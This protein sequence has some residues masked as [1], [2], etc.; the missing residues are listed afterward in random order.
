MATLNQIDRTKA[1]SFYGYKTVKLTDPEMVALAARMSLPQMLCSDQ[2]VD[3]GIKVGPDD[4]VPLLDRMA[5][6]EWRSQFEPDLQC[7]SEDA[8][9][10]P[11]LT[12]WVSVDVFRCFAESVADLRIRSILRTALR[13]WEDLGARRIYVDGY[14]LV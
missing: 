2:P 3:E 9:G 13:K 4:A 6:H 7:I 10:R 8:E 14:K 5:E 1:L 11:F 12:T